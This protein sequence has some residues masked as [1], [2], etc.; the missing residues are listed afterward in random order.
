M[1][2]QRCGRPVIVPALEMKKC[3]KTLGISKIAIVSAFGVE[4]GLLEQLFFRNHDIEVTNFI[5]I[6]DEP[7]SDRLKIDQIDNRLILEKVRQADFLR[8]EAVYFDSPTYKLRPIIEELKEII[9]VP[10]FSVNQVLIYSALKRLKLPTDHLPI[11]EY[12]RGK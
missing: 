12:F 8:A 9:H 10:M 3:L 2:E 4:L 1:L 5:N 7:S 6:F 11:A